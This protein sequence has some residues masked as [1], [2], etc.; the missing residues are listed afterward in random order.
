MADTQERLNT[1]SFNDAVRRYWIRAWLWNAIKNHP[2]LEKKYKERGEGLAAG[3]EKLEHAEPAIVLG[4]GPSLDEIATKLHNWRGK[5]FAPNSLSK[6]CDAI[7]RHP[8]YVV[9]IDASREIGDDLWGPH[10]YASTLITHPCVDP[11]VYDTW[12]DNPLKLLRM[13]EPGNEIINT[14]YQT[15]YPWIGSYIINS[16]CVTNSMILIASMLGYSPIY[17]LGHDFAYPNGVTRFQ[18]FDYRGNFAYLPKRV[19]KMVDTDDPW[20][21]PQLLMSDEGLLTTRTMIFYKQTFLCNYKLTGAQLINMSKTSILKPELPFAE[22]DDVIASQ[23]D[24]NVQKKLAKLHRTRKEID[25]ICDNYLVPRGMYAKYHKELGAILGIEIV[26]EM[27]N[28]IVEAEKS[29]EG[30]KEGFGMW[31]APNK[32]KP[33]WTR[34]DVTLTKT[35]DWTWEEKSEPDNYD[36]VQDNEYEIPAESLEGSTRQDPPANPSGTATAVI[37]YSAGSKPTPGKR[38]DSADPGRPGGRPAGK[39]VPKTKR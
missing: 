4:A 2:L 22:L 35:P 10:W 27:P 37:G 11:H 36:A 28:R 31:D 29:L 18:D 33:Y 26:G 1:V 3:T 38:S 8:D 25:E 16:G 12:G 17:L 19:K 15:L 6:W 32:E 13:F 30:L 23:W 24:V 9:A 20:E 34:K 5:V 7:G 21:K 14:M 39:G